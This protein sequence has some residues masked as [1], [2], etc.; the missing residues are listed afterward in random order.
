[1]IEIKDLKKAFDE[2]VIFDGFSLSL[3]DKGF[4]ALSG[5]SGAGKTTLFRMI[6][7]LD[8]GYA[9]EIN[10][11]GK[12]SYVFQEN[13]LLPQMTAYENVFTVCGDK[14]KS[15]SL[16]REVGLIDA[17]DKYPSELSGGMNRRVAIARALSYGHDILLLD[18]P[19]TALDADIRDKIINLIKELE[20]DKLLLI[21][22]H[23]PDEISALGCEEIKIND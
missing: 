21:I 20:K 13:R 18:E 11:N 7:G 10:A 14:E 4:Y 5:P 12:I 16:L 22:T 17:V 6:S 9:G 15:L 3:P 1:M 8:T 2:N 23:D 19:F